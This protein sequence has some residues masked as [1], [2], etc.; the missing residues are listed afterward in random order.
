MLVNKDIQTW[1]LIDWQHNHHVNYATWFLLMIQSKW[2]IHLLISQL[3][4]AVGLLV[5]HFWYKWQLMGANQDVRPSCI[6]HTKMSAK[7]QITFSI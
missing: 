1:F 7:Q 2:E 4:W 3:Q 5:Y 6:G